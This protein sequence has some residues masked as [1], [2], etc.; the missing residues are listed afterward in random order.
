MSYFGISLLLHA[1]EQST[2]ERG[3]ERGLFKSSDSRRPAHHGENWLLRHYTLSNRLY[4]YNC[5]TFRRNL[6]L[7]FP[8][9]IWRP[10]SGGRAFV[11]KD[12]RTTGPTWVGPTT[13]IGRN[14]D[15]F[16]IPDNPRRLVKYYEYLGVPPKTPVSYIGTQYDESFLTSDF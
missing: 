7:L 2:F 5:L 6:S 3:K 12:C 14:G 11:N 13:S 16:P 8:Q 9:L 4:T 1:P 10:G 15:I